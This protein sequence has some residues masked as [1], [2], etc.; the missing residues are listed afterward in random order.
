MTRKFLVTVA[1]LRL[2][3]ARLRFTTA[4]KNPNESITNLLKLTD[5][6]PDRAER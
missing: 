2:A 3:Y 6:T 1:P 5:T 4:T